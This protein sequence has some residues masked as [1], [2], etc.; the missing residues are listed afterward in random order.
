MD[1]SIEESKKVTQ[2]L[3]KNSPVKHLELLRNTNDESPNCWQIPSF[4]KVVFFI[5]VIHSD[6]YFHFK[7]CNFM[8]L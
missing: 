1:N 7:Y 8:Q 3:K 5:F 4:K 2:E 6:L